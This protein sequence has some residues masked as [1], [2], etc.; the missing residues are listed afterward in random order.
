MNST[1]LTTPMMAAP[2]NTMLARTGA[3]EPGWM[4]VYAVLILST[5]PTPSNMPNSTPMTISHTKNNAI[6]RTQ[7]NFN[8]VHGLMCRSCS[9]ARRG[10]RGRADRAERLAAGGAV[11]RVPADGRAAVPSTSGTA[12]VGASAV[13]SGVDVHMGPPDAP[14]AVDVEPHGVELVGE[15]GDGVPPDPDAVSVVAVPWRAAEAV[16]KPVLIGADCPPWGP[17]V[18]SLLLLVRF[19]GVARDSDHRHAVREVHQAHAHRLTLGPSNLRGLRANHHPVRRDRVDLVLRRD[20][21]RTDETASGGN[22]TRR[23]HTLAAS[24]LDRILAHPGSLGVSA[25]SGD[26]DFGLLVSHHGHREQLVT[27]VEPHP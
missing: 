16:W 27:L 22:D 8:T 3:S 7:E 9:R 4:S 21:D 11:G 18:M 20:D 26:Q 1:M 12:A 23:Q 14:D 6:D 17:C 10:P 24:P 13:P 15:D 19:L 25:L 2:P 5:M